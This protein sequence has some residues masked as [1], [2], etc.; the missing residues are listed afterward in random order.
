VTVLP[1]GASSLCV[2]LAPQPARLLAAESLAATLSQLAQVI[3]ALDDEQYSRR[4]VGVFES[5]IGGHARHCL[6]HVEAL[7]AGALTGHIDYD[8]RRRG[9]EIET[10]R[11][12]ALEAIRRQRA[13]LAWLDAKAA[14]EGLQLSVLVCP[15]HPSLLT[16]TT[17]GREIAFVLSHTVHHNALIAAMAK[18][19]G[20][21][22]PDRFGYAPA[23]I[24]YLEGQVCVR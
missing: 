19:M 1:T 3:A 15:A 17:I 4:P 6:D 10:N 18:T 23:T 24:A 14:D 9:T 5:S 21:R 20:I 8:S 22:V 11:M 13:R 12:A 2:G 16:E 7:L